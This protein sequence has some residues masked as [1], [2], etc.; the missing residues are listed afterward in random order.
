MKTPRYFMLVIVLLFI[1]SLVPLG[2]KSIDRVANA[3]SYLRLA[4]DQLGDIQQDIWNE[5]YIEDLD[6]Q[7]ADVAQSIEDALQELYYTHPSY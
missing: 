4:L 1:L 7:L 6:W 2:C 3:E 5:E